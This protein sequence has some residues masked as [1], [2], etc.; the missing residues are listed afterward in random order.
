MFLVKGFLPIV[1]LRGLDLR[2]K[3]DLVQQNQQ[4]WT[5]VYYTLLYWGEGSGQYNCRTTWSWLV[6]VKLL[7]LCRTTR[8]YPSEL[9]CALVV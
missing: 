1:I 2:F 8:N 4:Q 7:K 3:Q 5:A 9:L 6:K